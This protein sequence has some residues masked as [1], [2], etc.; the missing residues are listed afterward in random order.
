MRVYRSKTMDSKKKHILRPI[1]IILD[2]DSF[3]FNFPRLTLFTTK[4]IKK[5]AYLVEQRTY[6][7][8]QNL[9]CNQTS[10]TNREVTL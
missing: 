10:A 1:V 7:Q 6:G 3:V 2:E 8:R 4:A 9:S 5:L